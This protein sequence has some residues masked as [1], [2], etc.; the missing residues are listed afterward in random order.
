M[1][2]R[3]RASAQLRMRTLHKRLAALAERYI[4]EL[5]SAP[6]LDADK[7]AEALELLKMAKLAARSK[8]RRDAA[9]KAADAT[10]IFDASPRDVMR[11]LRSA[12]VRVERAPEG[13]LEDFTA[14]RAPMPARMSKRQR[15]HARMLERY[16][17]R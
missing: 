12:G 3:E 16:Q 15:E 1:V 6:N 11:G 7:L 13:A 17:E 2:P 9:E 8:R 5:E 14:S 10:R 4:R